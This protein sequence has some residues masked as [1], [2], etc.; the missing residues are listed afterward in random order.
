M[1]TKTVAFLLVIGITSCGGTGNESSS[2]ARSTSPQTSAVKP[3]EQNPAPV[4]E[5]PSLCQRASVKV[6]WSKHGLSSTSSTADKFKLG[7]LLYDEEDYASAVAVF[8]DVVTHGDK[9]DLREYAINLLLDALVVR[10][11]Q[12]GEAYAAHFSNVVH[13][14]DESLCQNGT[15]WEN[16][17]FCAPEGAIRVVCVVD[18][19]EAE[20]H[21]DNK[22]YAEASQKFAKLSRKSGCEG[23]A[24]DM[25][26]NAVVTAQQSEAEPVERLEDEF[27][28]R[29]PNSVLCTRLPNQAAR[30]PR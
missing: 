4:D 6:V 2:V 10:L 8:D 1:R 29:F 19:K 27:I 15:G 17:S 14:Y 18:R 20:R 30:C 11:P 7:R 25:L 21:A 23:I 5:E 9:Q 16:S 28:W 22:A 13:A 3:K 12:C 24:E 26:F